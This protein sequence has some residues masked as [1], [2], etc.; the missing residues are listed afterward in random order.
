MDQNQGVQLVISSVNELLNES[1]EQT[2]PEPADLNEGTQLIGQR[3][4]LTSLELVTLLFNIEQLIS[5]EFSVNVTI[6]D[7]RAMSRE[8]SPFRTVGSLAEYITQLITE[9]NQHV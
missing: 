3:G 5:D 8:K 1:D 6:A 4:I 7:D 9:C 2:R